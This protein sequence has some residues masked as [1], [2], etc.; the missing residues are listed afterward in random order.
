MLRI[1]PIASENDVCLRLEGKIVGAW[2]DELR[3]TVDREAARTAHVRLDLLD[4]IFVDDAGLRLLREL[5]AAGVRIG[6]CSRF[7]S[8]LLSMEKTP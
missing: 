8:E 7:V 5:A 1:T 4:V 3:R 2:V 6:R